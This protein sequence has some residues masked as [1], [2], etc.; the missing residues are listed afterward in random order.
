MPSNEQPDADP[1]TV[2]SHC[3]VLNLPLQR[4]VQPVACERA[5]CDDLAHVLPEGNTMYEAHSGT[6][7]HVD[8]EADVSELLALGGQ[9]RQGCD[10]VV[11]KVVPWGDVE[12]LQGRQPCPGVWEEHEAIQVEGG[13]RWRNDGSRAGNFA[14]KRQRLQIL[15]EHHQ[16]ISW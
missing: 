10:T 11:S 16:K 14:S 9:P 6:R 7:G 8:H 13:D 5:P 3:I 1:P 12:L 2:I 15:C 4:L